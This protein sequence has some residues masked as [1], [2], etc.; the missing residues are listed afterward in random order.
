MSGNTLQNAEDMLVIGVKKF[1]NIQ[2]KLQLGCVS[3]KIEANK[4]EASLD[5]FQ[6]YEAHER[7]Y[8]PILFIEAF[9]YEWK[10]LALSERSVL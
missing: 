5:S 4:L 9:N 10:K 6:N 7:F 2:I 8:L 1:W 3:R